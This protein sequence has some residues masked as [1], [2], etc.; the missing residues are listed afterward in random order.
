MKTQH[1]L[2]AV[3]VV[4]AV[5]LIVSLRNR[6]A[7]APVASGPQQT[8]VAN[9]PQQTAAPQTATAQAAAP[10]ATA[11]VSLQGSSLRKTDAGGAGWSLDL[12]GGMSFQALAANGA[13]AG[14]PIIVKTDVQRSG[15]REVSVGLRLE[16]QAGEQYR[17]VVKKNGT[18]VAA[19]ALR[20][21]NEA[22]KVVAQ[23]NF[24]Y[25]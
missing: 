4:V 10:Q 13:T 24:K 12:A 19:P 21:V 20:I 22:G 23:G 11:P 5:L 7:Q 3:G 14:A 9:Q 8:P 18:Q 25:G 17:P 2:V 16:G 15:D 1:L 6:P